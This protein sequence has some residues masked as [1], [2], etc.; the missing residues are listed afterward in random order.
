MSF[1]AAEIAET[2]AAIRR[3]LAANEAASAALAAE[4]R[5]GD[6]SL[7]AGLSLAAGWSQDA[8]LAAAL[9]RLPSIL[10]ASRESPPDEAVATLAK[11]ASLY[12]IGRGATFAVAAEAALKLKETSAIHAEAFSSA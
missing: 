12:V 11:A 9:D 3:Q 10:E 5:A 1:M 7:V 4:L 8:E 2:V 6:P